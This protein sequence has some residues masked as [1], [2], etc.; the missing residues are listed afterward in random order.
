MLKLEMDGF[1]ES[2]PRKGTQVRPI[3]PKDVYGQ[4]VVREALECQ[5]ARLYCG[6]PV[7]K[8]EAALFDLADKLNDTRPGTP[9]HWRDEINFHYALIELTGVPALIKEC[10]RAIHLN[11]FH[12][13]NRLVTVH[14]HADGSMHRELVVG[15]KTRDP[16]EAEAF[17]REHIRRGKE[18]L[19]S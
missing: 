11:I 17:I 12:A 6:E 3:T 18:W 16:G 5:A 15:L 14:D 10:H 4:M 9:Q 13:I 7:E 2:I 8:H 19:V 1:L